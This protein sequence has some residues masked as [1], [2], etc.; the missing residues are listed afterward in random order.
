VG[1]SFP[2][3][4][5]N[6]ARRFDAAILSNV[7]RLD[8]P[9]YVAREYSTLERFQM[10]RLDRTGWLRF[11]DDD[12]LT[13]VLRAVAEVH[14]LRVLD[15]GCG[16]GWITAALTAPEV[17]AV[18]QSEASV[19]AA[20]ARGLDAQVA[21]IRELPFSEGS[22]DAVMCNHVLYHVEH[23][24]RALAEI[25]RVLRPGGRFVGI[26]N[27]SDHLAEVWDAV[28]RTERDTGDFDCEG[29]AGELA[30]HFER[31]ECRPTSGSV[32]W[33]ERQDLQAYL[34]AYSEMLGPLTAPE[35]PY[36]FFAQR[37]NCVLVGEKA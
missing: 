33:L 8:D 6:T 24:E 26:Y 36:P 22:F 23:R 9:D 29:G 21:D 5:G 15:A 19:A 11:G 13:L 31:I 17:V 27:F 1:S 30:G 35:G 3:D 28:G 12:E 2:D 7:H 14:P 32:V 20:R 10:R 34:D 4:K 16:D 18:D 37:R 25:A